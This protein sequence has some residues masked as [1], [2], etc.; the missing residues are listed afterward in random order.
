MIE[1][2]RRQHRR[3]HLRG[4]ASAVTEHL[5]GQTRLEH[6][7]PRQAGDDD[8]DPQLLGPLQAERVDRLEAAVADVREPKQ[9][10]T[11]DLV[12]RRSGR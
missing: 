12:H 4:T 1:L 7:S 9:A 5:L 2:A 11:E 3:V 6:L 8:R 10:V